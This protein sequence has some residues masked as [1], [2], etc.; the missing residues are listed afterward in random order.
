MSNAMDSC[1]KKHSKCESC[2]VSGQSYNNF[3]VNG[4]VLLI[5]A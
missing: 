2:N 4:F 3:L 1:S 5:G